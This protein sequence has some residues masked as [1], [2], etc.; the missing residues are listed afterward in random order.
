MSARSSYRF[1][2]TLLEV[3]A[4]TAAV[5]GNRH[6]AAEFIGE[7]GEG[8]FSSDLV[9]GYVVVLH[10]N[11]ALVD[12]L[13]PQVVQGPLAPGVDQPERPTVL[14]RPETACAAPDGVE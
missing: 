13:S 10:V 8:N 14:A 3:A 2:G 1:C 9:V 6:E 11:I 12:V 7:A 5:D 4:Y